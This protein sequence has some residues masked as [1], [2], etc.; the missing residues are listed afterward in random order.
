MKW[1][2]TIT[3][4]FAL[5]AAG[6]APLHAEPPAQDPVAVD[7]P[8]KVTLVILPYENKAG[9]PEDRHWN[10][11]TPQRLAKLLGSVESIRVVPGSTYGMRELDIEAGDPIDETQARRIG[12]LTEVRW[13]TR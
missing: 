3:A 6:S 4:V 13:V 10:Y 7:S 9:E 2:W 8:P 1:Q 12:E 5:T 11:S